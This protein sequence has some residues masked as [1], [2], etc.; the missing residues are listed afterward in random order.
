MYSLLQRTAAAMIAVAM[1][2]V[3]PHFASAQ[4]WSYT[5][6]VA[7][8]NTGAA[9]T[10]Y[11]A[12]VQVNT[13]A[14]ISAGKMQADGDDI[15]FVDGGGTAIA[16][17]VQDG[18]NTTT[19]N[20]WLKIPSLPNGTTTITMRYGNGCLSSTDQASDVFGTGIAALYTFTEGSGSTLHD[21]V[22]GHDLAITSLTWGT[23]R[24]SGVGSLSGFSGGRAYRSASG[25]AIGTGSF[26]AYSTINPTS[27]SGATNGIIGNYNGDG[28]NGWT[29]K[30][31]GGPGQ[32]MMITNQGGS[33]CQQ[34]YGSLTGGAWASVAGVRTSGVIN[35][36]YQNGSSV[37]TLC[38]GDARNVDNS[39]PFE[40]GRSYNGNYA[41]N[42][43]ISLSAVYTTDLSSTQVAALEAS[44]YPATAPSISV[45][46]E[47]ATGDAPVITL[48][49]VNNAIACAGGSV[50]FTAGATGASS[51]WWDRSTDGGATWTTIAG[52][53]S[54]T[55]TINPTT[56]AMNGNLVR[57]VFGS[58]GCAMQVSNAATITLY[59]APSLAVTLSPSTIAYKAGKMRSIYA[60]ITPSGNCGP[61][62][63]ALQSITANEAILAT[64]I[65]YA[66]FNTSPADLFFNVAS[67][68]NTGVTARV[69]TVTYRV[70]DAA[71]YVT[72]QTATVTVPLV[73]GMKPVSPEEETD[74]AAGVAM[75]EASTSTSSNET[76]LRFLINGGGRV[77]L[78][79]YD[80]AG[81]EVSRLVDETREAGVYFERWNAR[82]SD[83]MPVPA[84]TY[85]A[86]VITPTDART[87]TLHVV[88]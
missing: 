86:R 10:D 72:T 79:I 73:G 43:A 38:A 50:S 88:R 11:F 54:T 70:T 60:S 67:T 3:L 13:A 28:T 18:I 56:P 4:S 45:G 6:P 42:G 14:L 61:F 78:A 57:A 69:Y 32:F 51:V 66:S 41:F 75:F 21:W 83:G 33:W 8:T 55:L 81:R 62:T 85:F 5:R 1:F 39:G 44:L 29:V 77:S 63:T 26:T 31:Q 65:Q 64:D 7:I 23:G 47:A 74:A 59:G 52:A 53:T 36:L 48:N 35:T 9:L 2:L 46:T 25:P 76:E 20:I 16:Y 15:R 17:W 37:G 84:G 49:P 40:I 58:A 80:A 19:T 87:V 68:R 71:G 30:L 34:A 82:T 27:P 12:L 24:R 22:G